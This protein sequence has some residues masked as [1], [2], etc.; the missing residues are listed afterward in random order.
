MN[1]Y[2]FVSANALQPV[3]SLFSEDELINEPKNRVCIANVAQIFAAI[4]RAR[5]KCEN[6]MLYSTSYN[7][8][9]KNKKNNT[10]E[11]R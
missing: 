2:I 8:W 3:N 11:K 7:E 6:K 5:E 1:G 4:D 9:V 10:K